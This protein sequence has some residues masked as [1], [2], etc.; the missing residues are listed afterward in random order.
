MMSQIVVRDSKDA[1]MAALRRIYAHHVLHGLGSFEEKPPP[2][3]ELRRRRADV[4]EHGLPYL[5]AEIDGV[6][7]GYGYAAPYRSRSAYRYTLEDS[8]YV[9]E[10][11]SRRGIG[12]ALLSA[13]ISRCDTGQWRQMIAV[14]GDSNNTASIALHESLGF[15]LV[16]TFRA[17]G[18]KL[19]RWVDTV[20]M[21]R[22]LGA[23][24]RMPPS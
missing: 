20:L 1:D 10:T 18:F 24:A 12:R 2:L 5:V 22:E 16:G 3:A 4:L 13:V 7:T 23:G 17:V 14:I 11:M 6:V 19:G 21:Q 8:V 15:R 9:D